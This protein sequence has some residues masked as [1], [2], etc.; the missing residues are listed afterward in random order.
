M[1]RTAMR[2]MG[3]GMLALAMAVGVF[4]G[5]RSISISS[6]TATPLGTLA[7]WLFP[8]HFPMLE[9]AITRHIHPALWDPVV[10][11][12]LLVPAV[13]ALFVAGGLLLMLGQHR[14]PPAIGPQPPGV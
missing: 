6:A 5:A 7:F 11:T 12:L 9:P 3:Y 8:R 2:W 13:I 1:L 4:D 10:I 14:R